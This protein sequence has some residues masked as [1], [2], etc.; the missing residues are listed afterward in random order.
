VQFK[1]EAAMPF[2]GADGY[3]VILGG[4]RCQVKSSLITSPPRAKAIELNCGMIL[5][6]SAI[7][8]LEEHV[9]EGH[10]DADIYLFTFL[11]ARLELST[12]DIRKVIQNKQP[13]SMLYCMPEALLQPRGWHPIGPLHLQTESGDGLC[14]QLVGLDGSRE[15]L[16]KPIKLLPGIPI[17]IDEP[18]FSLS[19]LSSGMITNSRLKIFYHGVSK[20]LVIRPHEWVNI[21]LYGACILL[22]GFITRREFEKKAVPIQQARQVY[23][24]GQQQ[25][26][27]LAI[28]VS[29]LRPV[30]ELLDR[31]RFPMGKLPRI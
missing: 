10:S 27:M 16:V 29:E 22:A 13:V 2:T 8:P 25:G 7:V 23:R 1:T 4:H 5:G 18:Y 30:A 20:P 14:M 11:P 3:E 12:A 6:E 21:R 31:A 26:K 15:P 9:G 24:T 28:K 17:T 19:A